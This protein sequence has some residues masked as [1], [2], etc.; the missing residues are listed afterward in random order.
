MKAL[1]LAA[2]YATRLYP[3]TKDRPK[4]LLAVAGKPMM[5]YILD[6]IASIDDITEIFVV[7]NNKFHS[8]FEEWAK[9]YDHPKPIKIINDNTM[10][11]EDKLGA[12]GD[13][14][15]VI[16]KEN[17]NEDLMV[18]AGDNL[19]EF[20]LK[21]F[22][23]FFKQKK[24]NTIAVYD[25]KDMEIAKRMGVVTVD[26]N[27][28]LTFFQEKPEKPNTTLIAICCYLFPKEKLKRIKEFLDTGAKSDAPGY[29]I[30]WLYKNDNVYCFIFEDSWFDIGN[31]DQYKL[32][33]Q[34]YEKKGE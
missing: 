29:Y 1:I 6:K 2:G 32:A 3:L 15:F 33:N 11:D 5:E 24:D 27:K 10:S 7:T 31:L 21:E 13:I 34:V 22:V 16:D 9:N 12:V 28:K 8:H 20:D 18:I 30:Q 25:V 23:E 17:L 26:E 19:F 4:P 14:Q